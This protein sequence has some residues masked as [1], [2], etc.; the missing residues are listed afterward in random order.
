M[1]VLRTQEILQEKYDVA[2]DVTASR[3]PAA[4][5]KRGARVE[6]WNRLHPTETAKVPVRRPGA[7]W[8]D[9]DHRRERLHESHPRSDLALA[10]AALRADGDRRF[11]RSDTREALRRH[12]EVDAASIAAASLNALAMCEQYSPQDVAKAI[13]DSGSIPTAGAAHA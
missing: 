8:R 9:A 3:L 13:A 4:G 12:F 5:G 6:R 11:G 7:S 2:A 10:L 1:Q